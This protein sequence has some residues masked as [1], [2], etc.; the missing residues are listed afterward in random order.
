MDAGRVLDGE[1][2]FLLAVAGSA[3]FVAFA[4]AADMLGLWW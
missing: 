1:L 3:S 4:M 2:R